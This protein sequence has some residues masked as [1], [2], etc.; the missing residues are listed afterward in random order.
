MKEKGDIEKRSFTDS[1]I[2]PKLS[3]HWKNFPEDDL[4]DYPESPEMKSQGNETGTETKATPSQTA[5]LT[6]Q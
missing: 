3:Q 5:T 1:N 2:W 6:E 4:D